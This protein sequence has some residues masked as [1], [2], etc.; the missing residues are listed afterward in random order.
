MMLKT[1]LRRPV[2]NDGT[3]FYAD[4]ESILAKLPRRGIPMILH[5][6]RCKTA[7]DK[8]KPTKLYSASGMAKLVRR[9]CAKA[10]YPKRSWLWAQVIRRRRAQNKMEARRLRPVGV[11]LSE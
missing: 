3:L 10:L 4:A 11:S 2:S 5:E 6:M 8:P 7:E 1:L 9:I